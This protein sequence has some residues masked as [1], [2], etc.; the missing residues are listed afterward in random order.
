MK[1]VT[2]SQK[3]WVV[4]PA[5][6][7]K[8]YDLKSGSKVTFA[9][10]EGGIQIIPIPDDPIAALTGMFKDAPELLQ[11]LLDERRKETERDE[12]SFQQWSSA[13]QKPSLTEAQ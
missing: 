3:G 9:E 4:I 10:V 12:K 11:D 5:D 2:V 6:L 8:K 13:E 7:R 1:T